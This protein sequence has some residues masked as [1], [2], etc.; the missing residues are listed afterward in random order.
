MAFT[1][2][3]DHTVIFYLTKNGEASRSFWLGPGP[4]GAQLEIRG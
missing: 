2:C 3:C 4:S 1:Q